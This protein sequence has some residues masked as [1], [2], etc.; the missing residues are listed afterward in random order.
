MYF[1]ALV[2]TISEL[3]LIETPFDQMV[4]FK[5]IG[6]FVVLDTETMLVSKND[7]EYPRVVIPGSPFGP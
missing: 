1:P 7:P 6:V 2:I 4:V 5:G 3:F